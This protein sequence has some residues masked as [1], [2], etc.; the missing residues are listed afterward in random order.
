MRSQPTPAWAAGVLAAAFAVFLGGFGLTSVARAQGGVAGDNPVI[1]GEKKTPPP[2]NSDLKQAPIRVTTTLVSTPVTVLDHY[3]NYVY[4]LQKRDFH[5]YDNGVP[6]RIERFGLEQQPLV[7][8]IVVQTNE[9]VSKLLD[10]VHPLGSI[11]S[12]LM[13]GPSGQAAVLTYGNGVNQV[14]DFT[15]DSDQLESALRG[16][17]TFGTSSHLNDA[18]ALALSMLEKRPKGERRIIVAFSDGVDFGSQTGSGTIVHRAVND[19]VT[20]YGL[21][22]TPGRELWGQPPKAPTPGPMDNNVTLPLPPN[23]PRTPT[24]M[25]QV[26]ST[27]IPI[28][29]IILAG[30]EM[31][32]SV[33]AKN[34][35]EFYAGYSGGVFYSHWTKKNLQESLDHIASEIHSQY[36][37]AY[38]PDTLNQVGFHRI[39]VQVEMPGVKVRTR[40]GYFYQGPKQ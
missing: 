12:S 17:K 40:A 15:S 8:V 2:D 34:L 31:V 30:G 29:P 28:V 14:L 13:L 26:Y 5:V 11:F 3:G 37:L 10:L 23:T 32:R 4:D 18:M 1:R 38:I 6:Q 9:K 21:G 16:L 22:F 39:E 27:P 35:M 20:I 7:A 36:E 25:G 24:N 19:E 33:L